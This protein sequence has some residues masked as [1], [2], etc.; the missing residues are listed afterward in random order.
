MAR[1]KNTSMMISSRQLSNQST[2]L[3]SPFPNQLQRT[4]APDLP[5]SRG[6]YHNTV[7]SVLF[8]FLFR[9]SSFCIIK[10]TTKCIITELAL[11]EPGG[12][13]PR[14]WETG[15][16]WFDGRWPVS[17]MMSQQPPPPKAQQSQRNQSITKNNT[18]NSWQR[19]YQDR[20]RSVRFTPRKGSGQLLD[21]P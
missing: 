1:Y 20:V 12:E 9:Y 13:R 5:Y 7:T 19:Y 8:H 4:P 21:V 14:E 2:D 11:E 16:N 18:L 17:S 3:L 6:L 10:T 15:D